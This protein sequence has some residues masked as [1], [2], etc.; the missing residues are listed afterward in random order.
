VDALTRSHYLD[1]QPDTALRVT[2]GVDLGSCGTPRPSWC[3]RPTAGTPA[4]P[5]K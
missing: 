2:V 4:G 1:E 3:A 5:R